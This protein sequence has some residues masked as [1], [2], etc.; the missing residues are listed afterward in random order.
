MSTAKNKNEEEVD[1]GSLFTVIGNGFKN[2]FNFIGSIF[3]GIFPQINLNFNF[4]QITLY[5]VYYS[6]FNRWNSW[7]LFRK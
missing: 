3:K 6:S 2:F 4:L 5:K 1:L 7:I